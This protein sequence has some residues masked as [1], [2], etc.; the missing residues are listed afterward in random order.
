MK[1]FVFFFTVLYFFT[2]MPGVGWGDVAKFQYEASNPGFPLDV[3]KHPWYHLLANA[4]DFLMPF[5]STAWKANFLSLLLGV[6][7]LKIF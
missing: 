5:G 3:V 2:L 7:T 4:F 1:K 6:F